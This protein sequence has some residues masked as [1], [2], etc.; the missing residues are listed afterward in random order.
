MLNHYAL[1]LAQDKFVRDVNGNIAIW[2]SGNQP[3]KWDGQGMII[4][5]GTDPRYDWQAT[6]PHMQK[7][8]IVNPN[9][10]VSSAN[11][12]VTDEDYPIFF[13]HSF[14]YHTGELKL[15]NA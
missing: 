8:H 4:V 10:F 15:M 2:H 7:P 14:G 13:L 9:G 11:Q 5:D 1:T 12:H 6:I 3:A